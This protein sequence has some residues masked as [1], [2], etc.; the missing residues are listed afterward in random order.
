MALLELLVAATWAR[1][2]AANVLQRVTH[3]FLM[4]MAAIRTVDMAML[5]VVV[6]VAMIVVIV[7]AIGAMHMG[8]L[9]HRVTPE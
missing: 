2:V 7:I 8:L 4:G 3:R 1:I 6:G 9:V 5:V